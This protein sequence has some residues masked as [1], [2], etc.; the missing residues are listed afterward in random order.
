MKSLCAASLLLVGAYAIQDGVCGIGTNMLDH[1]DAGMTTFCNTQRMGFWWNWAPVPRIEYTA[2]CANSTFVP[3]IWGYNKDNK[4]ISGL[5]AKTYPSIIRYNEP[6]HYA[7]PAYPGGDYL[8]SG[9]FPQ[10]FQ[11][12]KS[13][14]ATNWQ[15][16]VMGYLAARPNGIIISPAM[17][18]SGAT[19]SSGN[20]G[21]QCSN[22]PQSDASHMPD[23]LGWLK[24]FK[25]AVISLNCGT[26]N[27][28]DVINVIQFHAYYYKASDLIKKANL[29][30]STWAEDLQALNGR[31]KKT[32]WLTEFAHAGTTDSA[33]PDGQASKFMEESI[34]YM[35]QSP[36]FSGWSWFSQDSSTFASFTIDGIKPTSKFWASDLI[37]KAGQLTKIGEK[38]VSLCGAARVGPSLLTV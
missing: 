19:A 30:E 13:L 4:Y 32:L 7:P 1:N 35:K 22:S 18:D 24:C 38:Y 11:C 6:D 23:C 9:S 14:I 29:Y 28:W 2:A 5:A 27:C 33:D 34:N 20:D 21:E 26:T 17:A 36:Y 3:M 8:S 25:A 10:T 12:G 15:E 31:S 37:N 16:T